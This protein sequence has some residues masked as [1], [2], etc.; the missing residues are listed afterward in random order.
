MSTNFNDF[1]VKAKLPSP[2]VISTI[3]PNSVNIGNR[4]SFYINSYVDKYF[5]DRQVFTA[6]I[7]KYIQNL[8]EK[9]RDNDERKKIIKNISNCL[10]YSSRHDLVKE[11]GPQLFEQIDFACLVGKNNDTLRDI[12]YIN[13]ELANPAKLTEIYNYV[14]NADNGVK[15]ENFSTS[16]LLALKKNKYLSQNGQLEKLIEETLGTKGSAL[17][18]ELSINVPETETSINIPAAAAVSSLYMMNTPKNVRS[19][20]NKDV[21]A[22][23]NKNVL[24]TT[25]KNVLPASDKNVL[26]TTNRNVLATTNKNVLATTNKN[27]LATTNKNILATTNRN[28]LAANNKNILAAKQVAIN[29]ESSGKNVG[30][31]NNKNII[32]AKQKIITENKTVINDTND[33]DTREALEKIKQHLDRWGEQYTGDFKLTMDGLRIGDETIGVYCMLHFL[34]DNVDYLADSRDQCSQIIKKFSGETNRLDLASLIKLS[35]NK[36][37]LKDTNFYTNLY[38]FNI[39]MVDYVSK[40]KNITALPIES[41]RNLLFNLREFI[42]QSIN[43]LNAYMDEYTIIDDKLINSSYDLLYLSNILTFR[44]A[45]LGKN[46]N[47]INAIYKKLVTAIND[48]LSI[49][50]QID[51]SKLSGENDV[52]SNK[53]SKEI[54]TI[55]KKLYEKLTVLEQQKETLRASVDAINT[56]SANLENLVSPNIKDI[57]VNLK[58]QVPEINEAK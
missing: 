32:S 24:A 19:I 13:F 31:I 40:D 46:I 54:Q 5:T 7:F 50:R 38:G 29:N 8:L 20:N 18:E 28:V 44:H 30:S 42:K 4:T 56:N 39:A 36:D 15:L 23:T 47:D 35:D 58:T 12:R 11:I 34:S 52:E 10:L 1:I 55:T 53:L 22:A 26:A 27:V 45:N 37:F 2:E 25:N 43:Y 48:N 41:Q 51:H 17:T 49:Y 16:Q 9:S 33:A 21:L 14:T 6:P 57:A 3:S